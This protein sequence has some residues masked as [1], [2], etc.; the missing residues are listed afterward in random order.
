[1]TK[2]CSTLRKN[3]VAKVNIHLSNGILKMRAFQRKKN[4]GLLVSE[5]I[6]LEHVYRRLTQATVSEKEDSSTTQNEQHHYLRSPHSLS[7]QLILECFRVS[8]PIAWRCYGRDACV[9]PQFISAHGAS[10][11]VRTHLCVV[12][13][14]TCYMSAGLQ[15]H[16]RGCIR[17]HRRT[18][19]G[20]M[21]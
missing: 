13:V 3:A 10:V 16:A 20:W 11:P 18:C 4:E 9:W 12:R 15:T 6:L 19:A 2:V 17:C 1:M 8:N 14:H 5:T 21:S 7:I